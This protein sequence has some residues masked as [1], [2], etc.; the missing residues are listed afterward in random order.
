MFEKENLNAG[1]GAHWS[2][3]YKSLN[4]ENVQQKY[5]NKVSECS[6]SV[7]VSVIIVQ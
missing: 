3:S 6:F 5:R 4:S 7:G 1:A 2:C